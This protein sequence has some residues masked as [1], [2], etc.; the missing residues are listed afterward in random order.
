MF[1]PSNHW[2]LH[3]CRTWAKLTGFFFPFP[4]LH[5]M[6]RCLSLKSHEILRMMHPSI[7][8]LVDPRSYPALL[9]ALA[10]SPALSAH[11]QLRGFWK[12]IC[13]WSASEIKH[14]P[15][16]V[17]SLPFSASYIDQTKIVIRCYQVFS[18]TVPP[19]LASFAIIRYLDQTTSA[20]KNSFLF[21]FSE[22]TCSIIFTYQSYFFRVCEVMIA[23]W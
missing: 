9:A 8:T 12:L 14:T 23:L 19:I 11:S 5:R 7:G 1:L 2:I 4:G 20:T 13:Q 17:A 22:T 16:F 10:Q 21:R 15:F 3:F 18:A 6:R